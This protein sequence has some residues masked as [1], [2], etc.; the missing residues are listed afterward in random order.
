LGHDMIKVSLRVNG[1]DHELMVE[2]RKL[3]VHVL[4]EDLGLT[5]VKIGCDTSHCGACTVLMDGK[6]VKS[7]NVLAAMAD[8][9]EIITLE[10]LLRDDT[11]KAIQE[12]FWENHALQCGYCTPGFLMTTYSMLKE[13][14]E[15]DD[16]L[17]RAYLSGNMCMC[18]GYVNIIKA[19]KAVYERVRA[20]VR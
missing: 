4:R 14:G 7:C 8:G 6:V 18:T 13:L 2:P 12:S 10:G 3:L 19:V 16:G 1:V 15:A 11:M 17:I 20:H 9:S 5:S